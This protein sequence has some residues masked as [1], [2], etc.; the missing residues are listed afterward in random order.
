MPCPLE[1]VNLAC[2]VTIFLLQA[3]LLY[4]HCSRMPR[5][6]ALKVSFRRAL[7]LTLRPSRICSMLYRLDRVKE[8]GEGEEEDIVAEARCR[9]RGVK[10]EALREPLS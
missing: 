8:E 6:S 2:R 9:R 5:S 1:R 3:L 4:H 10:G 7:R